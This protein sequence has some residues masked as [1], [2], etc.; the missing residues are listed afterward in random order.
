MPFCHDCRWWA[1]IGIY[2]GWRC[3]YPGQ[4]RAR[5]YFEA[6]D[7]ADVAPTPVPLPACP[8]CGG[9]NPSFVGVAYVVR[10]RCRSCGRVYAAQ[11]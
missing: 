9:R 4:C 11:E 5:E 2:E 10:Y 3:T 6:I 1:P 8:Y 7:A